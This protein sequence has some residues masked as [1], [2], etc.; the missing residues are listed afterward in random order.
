MDTESSIQ[1]QI[2]TEI[3]GGPRKAKARF[4][5]HAIKDEDATAK[6][7]YPVYQDVENVLIVLGGGTEAKS[8]EFSYRATSELRA[9]HPEAY[10]AFKA[11][12]AV[13]A[14]TLRVLPDYMPSIAA[15]L[16]DM[17]INSIEML[18]VAD[19]PAPLEP[20][21]AWAKRYVA[22]LAGSK[23]R[24]RLVNGEVQEVA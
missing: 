21:K 24:L 19:V 15:T 4:Y 12:C 7:G 5:W 6:A 8:E 13:R 22:F 2:R 11:A 10:A 1:E 9:E 16:A 14:T 3:F 17:G 18:A 23:P 20:Q